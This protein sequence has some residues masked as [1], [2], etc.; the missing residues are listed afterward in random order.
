VTP[1]L[2]VREFQSAYR[3]AVDALALDD[4]L[5]YRLPASADRLSRRGYVAACETLYVEA[6]G[7]LRGRGT[8]AWPERVLDAGGS[9]AVFAAALRS[10]GVAVVDEPAADD[11]V[12]LVVGLALHGQT[13]S[14]SAV[15]A[16]GGQLRP[17]GRLVLAVPSSHY[18]PIR[19][20]E[21]RGRRPVTRDDGAV[22]LGTPSYSRR[23]LRELL[24][25]SGLDLERVQA[26]D[27]S[28]AGLGGPL[29]QTVSHVLRVAPQH[30]E[31]WL[32]LATRAGGA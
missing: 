7:L 13:A 15:A 25:R 22:E 14:A 6:L 26:L 30:R 19:L 2:D 17:N 10:L 4:E 27:Y 5:A 21:L 23:G 20:A 8:A 11:P 31:V 16:A 32:A 12:D 3:D 9:F 1:A 28:P 18:W 24:R 29:R